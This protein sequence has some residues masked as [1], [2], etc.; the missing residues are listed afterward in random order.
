L[1]NTQLFPVTLAEALDLRDEGTTR[2]SQTVGHYCACMAHEL[3]LDRHRVKR[4]RIAGVLHDIG[5]IG[6]HDSILYKPG[7]LTVE[8]WAQMRGHPEI[9]QRILGGSGLDDVRSWILAHHER[10]D[11]SGYPH[12][13]S[14]EEIPLEARILSVADAYEAMTSDRVYRRAMDAGAAREELSAGAGTQFD[15]RV[16]DT[17]LRVVPLAG[18]ARGANQHLVDVNVGGLV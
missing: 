6:V 17:F 16:V 14:G 11:G 13:L 4:I 2:H 1:T 12:G 8:E 18:L 9:G 5:K 15:A 3:G 7:P 10:P